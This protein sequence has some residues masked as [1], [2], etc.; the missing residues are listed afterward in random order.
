MEGEMK[1]EL[2]S[3]NILRELAQKF[4]ESAQKARK[5]FKNFD[6]WLAGEDYPTYSQL[7]QLSKIFDVPFGDFFL[8][9]LPQIRLPFEGGSKNFQDAVMHAKKV[10]NWAKE[11]LLEF[12]H[13][14]LPF[15]GK[16]RNGID[17][18]LIVEELKS[19][20]GEAKTLDEMVERAEKKG[21]FV[22][23]SGYIK[24]VR[25]GLDPQEFKG[26]VLF[27]DIA[28]VVF[29]NNKDTVRG[30]AFTLVHA[31]VHVLAGESAVFYWEGK[32]KACFKAVA[33]FLEGLQLENKETAQP[34][35]VNYWSRKFLTLLIEA[36]NNNIL[37]Y[38]DLFDIT[39]LSFR[40]LLPLLE[41][42]V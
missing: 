39:K 41:G 5:R 3:P 30:K 18:N 34:S 4:P 21:V 19:F 22:L 32:D 20:F 1:V 40:K 2:I 23:R 7:V 24:N 17:E 31:I 38:T 42:S 35:I 29:I 11:I 13:E 25:R 15:A 6:K 36:V 28:P 9:K 26:F 10:Q 27:D 16:Y 33:K 12:G 8:E 37:L 14:S